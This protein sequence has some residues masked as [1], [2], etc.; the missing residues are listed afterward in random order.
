M[1][2]VPPG[3][4]AG[5]RGGLLAGGEPGRRL[6]KPK[7]LIGAVAALV[8][9]VVAAVA[10]VLLTGGSDEQEAKTA[11]PTAYTPDYLGE[12]FAQIASRS[13]DTRAITEGE[14][15]SA[16][17]LKTGKYAFTLAASDL[18][19]D[20]KAGTWRPP[21]GRPRQGPVHPARPRRVRERRQEARRPVHRAEHGGRG[22]RQAGA[23]RPGPGDRRRRWVV[24]LK[25]PGVPAFGPGFSAAYAK[26]YG[27]YAVITWV[28]RA[29]MGS[30]PPRS[31]R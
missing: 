4:A 28:E 18:T 16:K 5:P 27:H 31:T 29:F 7:L 21:A 30:S 10:V 13:A 11:V 1:T 20:C 6:P 17:N 24:P 12:G 19:D 22:R 8:V 23:A 14:A 2:Q 15:F 3:R 26:T 9:V 25:A